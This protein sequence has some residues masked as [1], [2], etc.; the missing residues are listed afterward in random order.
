MLS[1]FA[2]LFLINPFWPWKV[3]RVLPI[4]V[5]RLRCRYLNQWE[6]KEDKGILKFF[7][8]FLF[9]AT[10]H[11]DILLS[12]HENRDKYSTSKAD[13]KSAPRLIASTNFLTMEAKEGFFLK[14]RA[15][16][17]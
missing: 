12:V 13:I 8:L 1:A 15:V 4:E 16:L 11:G 10:T 9:A 3:T 5:V 14:I 7:D 2:D 17:D 6:L